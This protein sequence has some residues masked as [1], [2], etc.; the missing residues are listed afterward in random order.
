MR[1]FVLSAF[2][3]LC[4]T[5]VARADGTAGLGDFGSFLEGIQGPMPPAAPNFPTPPAPSRSQTAGGDVDPSAPMGIESAAHDILE[6]AQATSAPFAAAGSALSAFQAWQG[7][8]GALSDLDAALS[9]RLED[10][11][12]G[13]EIPTSCGEESAREGCGECFA[14]AYGE[15][16]F[17][18]IV[19]E[20][21]RTLVTATL[22][23]IRSSESLGDTTSGIHGVSGLAW[24]YSKADIERARTGFMTTSREKYEQ[25]IENMRRALQMVGDCEREHFD[26]PD[27]YSRYGFM[28]LQYVKTAYEPVDQ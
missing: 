15:V 26:N 17:T 1:T 2:L 8:H 11:G 5:H 14:R 16:N 27:W 23:Y 7:Y 4:A 3:L 6:G 25:L 20:R 18:R 28:Y 24:Q 12:D 9:G 21:L 22:K 10:S 19:L 13:P